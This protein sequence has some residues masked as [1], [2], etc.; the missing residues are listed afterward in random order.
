MVHPLV[1]SLAEF[2]WYFYVTGWKAQCAAAVVCLSTPYWPPHTTVKNFSCPMLW[3]EVG[4]EDINGKYIVTVTTF[5]LTSF[6]ALRERRADFESKL[7]ALKM[8]F[9]TSR[10]DL[11]MK[12]PR[13]S[14]SVNPFDVIPSDSHVTY[15]FKWPLRNIPTFFIHFS[16]VRI[17]F[18]FRTMDRSSEKA[19][20]W[21][22]NQ[23]NIS[24]RP[25]EE[26]V[27]ESHVGTHLSLDIPAACSIYDS[28]SPAWGSFS[29]SGSALFPHTQLPILEFITTHLP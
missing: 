8:R 22:S 16:K 12:C 23:H 11:F 17:G 26:L 3:M 9:E 5:P 29:T 20:V 18:T 27:V 15:T 4:R 24:F 6:M 7:L 19:Q 14:P 28:T 2:R 1:K 21:V 13:R 10:K 25:F